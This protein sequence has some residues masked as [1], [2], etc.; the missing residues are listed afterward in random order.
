MEYYYGSLAFEIIIFLMIFGRL[1]P[2]VV[3]LKK[4]V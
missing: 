3:R 1:I 4:V 2:M